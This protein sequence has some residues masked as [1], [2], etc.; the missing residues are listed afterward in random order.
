MKGR[1]KVYE[2]VYTFLS[3]KVFR[4]GPPKRA[5]T[6]STEKE[7]QDRQAFKAIMLPRNTLFQSTAFSP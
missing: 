1:K 3:T 7:R 4:K 5:S 6:V 2:T